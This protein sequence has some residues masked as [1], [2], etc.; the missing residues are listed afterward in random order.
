MP[1]HLKIHFVC[2]RLCMECVFRFVRATENNNVNITFKH[3]NPF[4]SYSSSVVLTLLNTPHPLL[5]ACKHASNGICIIF[6]GKPELDCGFPFWWVVYANSLLDV[7]ILGRKKQ[8]ILR[9]WNCFCS[10]GAA[11]R[12]LNAFFFCMST[13]WSLILALVMCQSTSE[14]T[15]LQ[16]HW[17]PFWIYVVEHGLFSC[18]FTAEKYN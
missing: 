4:F 13:K 16:V 1:G 2:L 15:I 9:Y 3:T 7:S 11:V 10:T 17:C 18:M 5:K 14:N 6:N 12:F 8:T